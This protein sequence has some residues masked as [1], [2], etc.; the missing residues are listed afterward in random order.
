MPGCLKSCKVSSRYRGRR[1]KL[2]SVVF[3][4]A[5]CRVVSAAATVAEEEGEEEEEEVVFTRENRGGGGRLPLR[6]YW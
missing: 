4:S 6:P 3:T 1:R 5:H 2:S